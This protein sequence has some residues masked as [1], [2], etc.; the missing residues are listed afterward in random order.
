MEAAAKAWSGWEGRAAAASCSISTRNSVEKFGGGVARRRLRADR[1]PLRRERRVHHESV[2]DDQLLRGVK[3]IRDIPAVIVQGRYDIPCRCVPGVGPP[4][5]V[6]QAKFIV[7]AD[8]DIDD[9]A[10]HLR[11]DLVAETDAD[12][13]ALRRA[14]HTRCSAAGPARVV[15][16][17]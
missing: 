7:V 8:R 10:G 4:P 2:R 14:A 6:A 5:R 3:K 12:G 11:A 17:L 16:R 1:T 9:R 13:V 15:E